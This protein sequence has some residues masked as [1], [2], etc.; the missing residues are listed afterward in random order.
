VLDDDFDRRPARIAARTLEPPRDRV[1]DCLARAARER[2]GGV[3]SRRL[4]K[5]DERA[6]R[7]EQARLVLFL[8][9]TAR[10]VKRYRFRS[11]ERR[12]RHQTSLGVV[13]ST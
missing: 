2:R 7:D 9:L 8:D 10:E 13:D 3:A 5:T 6:R 4:A 12:M 1:A 11:V